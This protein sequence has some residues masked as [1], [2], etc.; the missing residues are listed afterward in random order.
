MKLLSI[1][2][3]STESG[4]AII[5]EEYKPLE[6]AKTDNETLVSEFLRMKH[7]YGVNM[8]VIEQ[9][10]S[11]GNI[12]G[13]TVLQTALW[14][15]RFHQGLLDTFDKRFHIAYVKRKQYVSDLTGN[16]KAKDSNVTQYLIDRFAPNVSN[17][18][19]GSKK[20]PGFF[21]GFHADVWQSYALAVYV[22]DNLLGNT[23]HITKTDFSRL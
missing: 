11:Y 14:S 13:D 23:A 4:W 3:G 18:G 22:M 9:L 10:S 5:N 21:Y 7:Q 8:A 17:R 19:K 15:G 2:P 1:D 12:I 16:P 6:F 20:E